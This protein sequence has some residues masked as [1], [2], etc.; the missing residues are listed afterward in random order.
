MRKIVCESLLGKRTSLL[1]SSGIDGSG[2]LHSLVSHGSAS[3]SCLIIRHDA[4]ANN[5]YSTG[6]I[7]HKTM[8]VENCNEHNNKQ[9]KV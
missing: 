1:R 8:V 2:M 4:L 5:R 3:A 9:A 6:L 7:G